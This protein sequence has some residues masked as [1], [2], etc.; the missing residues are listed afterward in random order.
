MQQQEYS[1]VVS[2]VNLQ[3]PHLKV[4]AIFSM[5]ANSVIEILHSA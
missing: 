1:C 2:D 4:E 5:K 3:L